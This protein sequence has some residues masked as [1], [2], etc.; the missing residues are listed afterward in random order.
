MT[1][2]GLLVEGGP[3][4]RLL[5]SPRAQAFNRRIQNVTSIVSCSLWMA[6]RLL[7]LWMQDSEESVCDMKEAASPRAEHTTAENFS[8]TS[9]LPFCSG[10]GLSSAFLLCKLSN[11][12]HPW[13][14]DAQHF[15][16]NSTLNCKSTYGWKILCL[17]LGGGGRG[18]LIVRVLPVFLY[19]FWISVKDKMPYIRKKSTEGF[20]L[21]L[22]LK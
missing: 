14:W 20:R 18:C 1:S 13:E 12:Q 6:T 21:V 2:H 22:V 5:L 8:E 4:M 16:K 17:S 10:L 7:R 9:C 3:V 15:L 19:I 11:N